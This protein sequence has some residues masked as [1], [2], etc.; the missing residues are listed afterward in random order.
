MIVCVHSE[1]RWAAESIM[2]NR[3]SATTQAPVIG[4]HR[5]SQSPSLRYRGIL[6]LICDVMSWINEEF[7]PTRLSGERSHLIHF[8]LEA[9]AAA[10]E[11]KV[12]VVQRKGLVQMKRRESQLLRRRLQWQLD[13]TRPSVIL[14]NKST[15]RDHM[16]S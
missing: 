12:V 1:A 11:G 6:L 7:N 14:L 13:T 15:E 10:L 5:Q 3:K 9:K 8:K 4:M 2:P 16:I